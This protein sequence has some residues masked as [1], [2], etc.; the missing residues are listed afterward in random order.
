MVNEEALD[1]KCFAQSK[2]Q[3]EARAWLAPKKQVYKRKR[4]LLLIIPQLRHKK[5]VNTKPGPKGDTN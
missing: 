2:P 1:L 3:K 4:A 5:C